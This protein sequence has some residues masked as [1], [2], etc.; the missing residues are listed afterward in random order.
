MR[1]LQVGLIAAAL[2]LLGLGRAEAMRVH[3]IPEHPSTIDP[4]KIVVEGDLEG[5]TAGF[6]APQV[7]SGVVVLHF[8]ALGRPESPDCSGAWVAA[9]DLP[10]LPAGSFDIHVD[11]SGTIL[12][13]GS[14]VVTPASSGF[15]GGLTVSPRLPTSQDRIE[16]GVSVPPCLLQ[17][18]PPNVAGD[19]IVVRLETAGVGV[20][21]PPPAASTPVSIGPL[22]AG[23]YTALYVLN[24]VVTATQ[25]FTVVAPS[26]ELDLL[27]Q[28][29]QATIQRGAP[30]T[31]AATAVRL[32]Q[33]SGYFWFFDRDNAEVTLKVLDGRAVNGHFWVFAASMTDVPFTLTITDLGSPGCGS[34]H[35]ATQT[36][37]SPGGKNTNFFDIDT[38]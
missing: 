35:C 24:G 4:L 7:T 8:F 23:N 37:T 16:L 33:E 27:Q 18:A 30:S 10:P 28:R 32:T 31:A 22:A 6:S 11:D 34:G 20:C 25:S 36:Y 17:L 2:A 21:P 3:V 12:A 26:L 19:R 5:C 13:A 38:F 9:F 15:Q 1:G 14:V 29:F